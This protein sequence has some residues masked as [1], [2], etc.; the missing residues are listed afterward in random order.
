MEIITKILDSEALH[1]NP[2]NDKP[3][4][5]VTIIENSPKE[6][7]PLLVGLAGF[8]GSSR[9][10]LNKSYTNIDFMDVL[11][12]ISKKYSFIIIL[13]D[14]MTYFRGNQYVNSTA[15]GNYS[16]FITKDLINFLFKIYG[17]RDV[18]L[19][20]KSSGGFGS[21]YNALHNPDIFSGF[22][23][24]SGDSYFHYSY[25]RDFPV[26]YKILKNLGIKK[27]MEKF[28]SDYIHSQDELTAENIIAMSAFYSPKNTEINLPF[29]LNDGGLNEHWNAWLKFDPVN[30]IDT[31]GISL[32]NK[33]I[34]L[35]TGIYD[36]YS[37][38]IGMN[39]IHEK[40][41]MLNISHT[42]KEYPVGHFNTN[43]LYLE[44]MP[45]ILK[46]Y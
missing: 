3:Q 6:N 27:F 18:Y 38:N 31:S 35:Q 10:F 20:G 7:T 42:Y 9:S 40:L 2:V 12:K 15:V 30:I 19:F 33:K 45:E 13:P 43:H 8:F 5:E 17:K 14:T 29:D 11:N 4:R 39:M 32:K 25:L 36:E 23:D 28:N 34:I 46:E 1:D 41:S 16:D 21:I 24:I 44:S 37:I 22:I 26:A